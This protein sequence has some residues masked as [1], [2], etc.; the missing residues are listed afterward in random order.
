[1][2]NARATHVELE[3]GATDTNTPKFRATHVE[4][5]FGATDTNTPKMRSTFIEL[6]WII[7]APPIRIT[8]EDFFS[9]TDA[10]ALDLVVAAT[11]NKRT[12]SYLLE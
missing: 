5:E 7:H 2:G 9:L 6:E 1:M 3:F 10:V 11:G 8:V 12:R 4:M